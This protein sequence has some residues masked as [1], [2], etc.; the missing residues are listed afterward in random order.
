MKIWTA[1]RKPSSGQDGSFM[2]PLPDDGFIFECNPRVPCFTDCCGELSLILTP[3][4]ILTLRRRLGLSSE[5][6]LKRYTVDHKEPQ[7]PFPLLLLRMDSGGA[8]GRCPF[9]TK[10]GCSVY[11]DRPGA[12][13]LYP[14]GRASGGGGHDVPVTVR[15][16][17]IKEPHCMGFGRGPRWNIESWIQSQGA[18][19]YERMNQ[20]WIE[21]LTSP[22]PRKWE[23]SHR[24]LQMFYLTCYNLERFRDFVLEGGF[25][26]R[27]ELDEDTLKMVREDDEALL[28]LGMRWLRFALY[29]EPTIKVKTEIKSPPSQQQA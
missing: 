8:A 22:N 20:P 25:L 18:D 15:Y 12:C 1:S 21:I 6:F 29:S 9:V 27:F 28:L 7:S 13:R 26:R 11:E 5:E 23:L 16:F 19:R 3:Y 17:I 24:H 2:V 14:V 10:K 4:D